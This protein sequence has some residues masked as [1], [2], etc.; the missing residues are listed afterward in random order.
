MAIAPRYIFHSDEYQHRAVGLHKSQTFAERIEKL[1][2]PSFN[3]LY[4]L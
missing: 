4:T 3:Q 2:V 1:P